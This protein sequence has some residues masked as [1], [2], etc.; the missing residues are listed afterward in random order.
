M[1]E[2]FL[3]SVERARNLCD[4]FL[5]HLSWMFH[6]VSRQQLLNELI[7][8]IYNKEALSG[9]HDL[10]LMLIVLGIG[11]LVD[12]DLP[13]YNLEAQHYYRL[14]RAAVTLQSVLGEQSVVTIKVVS[15]ALTD[16]LICL[17]TFSLPR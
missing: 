6:I 3:P 1:I 14:A 16:A 4:M 2:T 17:I 5:E 7:P 12:L 8:A 15:G 10:A 13:P 11:C 9:P